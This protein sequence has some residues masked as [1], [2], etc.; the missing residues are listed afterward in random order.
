MG[1]LQC[2]AFKNDILLNYPYQS[3]SQLIT[4]LCWTDMEA[5]DSKIRMITWHQVP[6]SKKWYKHRSMQQKR[7]GVTVTLNPNF[8]LMEKQSNIFH[9]T[10]K[11]PT[12]CAF[13]LSVSIRIGKF[14]IRSHTHVYH[15]QGLFVLITKRTQNKKAPS[16]G[17]WQYLIC[18]NR[19]FHFLY[20]RHKRFEQRT[21]LLVIDGFQCDER[22]VLWKRY[23][24]Y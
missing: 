1:K 11:E 12:S 6:E 24:P 2:R 4:L 15:Q 8:T 3:F 22:F 7:N 23:S 17:L 5:T 21:N 18:S 13:I 16:W 14:L 20:H 9:H 10:S 19:L